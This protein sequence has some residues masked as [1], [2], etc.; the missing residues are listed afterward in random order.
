MPIFIT[1]EIH[2]KDERTL[3]KVKD[4]PQTLKLNQNR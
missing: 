2:R 4:R 1:F 3:K